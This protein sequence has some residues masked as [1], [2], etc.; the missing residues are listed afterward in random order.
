MKKL[1]LCAAI[2]AAVLSGLAAAS[3][4]YTAS[5]GV[6]VTEKP[7]GTYMLLAEKPVGT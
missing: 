5:S 4:S 6:Q 7:V 3:N 2:T 1:I